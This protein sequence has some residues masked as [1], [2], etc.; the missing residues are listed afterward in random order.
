MMV[1]IMIMNLYNFK[2]FT[3]ARKAFL[4]VK[5]WTKIHLNLTFSIFKM[6]NLKKPKGKI[7]NFQIYGR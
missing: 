3:N 4:N 6:K 1:K 2:V 5:K 7:T